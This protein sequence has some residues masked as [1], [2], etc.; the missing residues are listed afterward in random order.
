MFYIKRRNLIVEESDVTKLIEIINK[1][2]G[3]FSNNNKVIGNCGWADEPTK[4]YLDFYASSKEWGLIAGELSEIGDITVK[5]S[6][7]KRMTHLYFTRK[8]S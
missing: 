8:E 5:T 6:P 7:N 4:W 1:H 3:F 2:Q